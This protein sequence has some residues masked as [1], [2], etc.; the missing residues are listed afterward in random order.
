MNAHPARAALG[1]LGLVLLA[2]PAMAACNEPGAL[3]TARVVRAERPRPDAPSPRFDAR[4][5]PREVALT[6]DDGPA[7]GRTEAVLDLLRKEC[8]QATFFVVG[9]RAAARP[10]LLRRMRDEGHAVGT[11]TFTHGDL[12]KAEPQAAIRDAEQGIAAAT[13]ALGR[14]PGLFRYPSWKR[15]D[16]VDAWLAGNGQRAVYAD[17]SPADWRGDP[18]PES[19]ERLRTRLEKRGRGVIVLH[20][21]QEPTAELVRLLIDYLKRHDFKVVQIAD[22]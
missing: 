16:A 20:D 6:F 8:I 12:S 14:R 18:A 21:V 15:T 5:G 1:A 7:P 4:L 3:G 2:A 22:G 11:H 9:R 13:T 10:D 17:I 19:F